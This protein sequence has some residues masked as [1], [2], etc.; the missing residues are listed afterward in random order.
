M[1]L[2]VACPY[3]VFLS[4]AK[5]QGFLVDAFLDDADEINISNRP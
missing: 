5:V 4:E 1:S 2:K 3:D